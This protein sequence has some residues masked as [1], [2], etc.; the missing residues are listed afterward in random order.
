LRGGRGC[1]RSL[2]SHSDTRGQGA[3]SAP[4]AAWRKPDALGSS[5]SLSSSSSGSAPASPA[6]K[7]ELELAKTEASTASS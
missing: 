4:Q 6:L 3:R 2:S 7:V 1:H 5:S